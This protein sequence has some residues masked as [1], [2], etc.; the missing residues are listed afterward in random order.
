MTLTETTKPECGAADGHALWHA[1]RRAPG[2]LAYGKCE[3]TKDGYYE[4]EDCVTPD[5]KN[6]GSETKGKYEWYANPACFPKKDGQYDEA[7]RARCP[8]LKKG[9]PKG[10]FEKAGSTGF[11]GVGVGVA[12]LEM[13]S[14][15]RW[16]ARRAARRAKPPERKR[17]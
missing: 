6:K 15:A 17:A 1:L 11:K 9:K 13:L 8:T 16:N 3:A 7:A 2:P 5:A 4:E 10:K 14:R 12:K